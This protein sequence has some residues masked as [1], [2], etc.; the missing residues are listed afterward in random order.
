MPALPADG[1]ALL[2][3]VFVL[4]LRH[5]ID[6]D[7]IATIDGLTR[8]ASA[9]GRRLARWCGALFALGHGAA[10][11]ALVGALALAS[12]QWHPP[13]WVQ[14]LGAG[15][16]IGL[17]VAL[18]LANLRAA[19][20]A[21][22][23]DVVALRGLRGRLFDGLLGSGHP[24]AALG[25]GA[26]FAVSFDTL[27]VAVMLALSGAAGGG[28]VQALLLGALFAGGMLLTDGSNGW[29]LA[30]LLSRAGGGAPRASRLLAGVVGGV[31]LSV[32]AI[33]ALR[34][35]WPAADAWADASSGWL[36]AAVLAGLL[37]LSAVVLRPRTANGQPAAAASRAP[38]A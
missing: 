27:G 4:G 31:S 23:G 6:A 19:V 17:L 38:A 9:R 29:W 37:A 8:L 26:L 16:S 22:P 34:W 18:G 3:L 30:R 35:A 28:P 1:S 20:G 25:I 11:L 12:R 21:A 36:G 7:H 32:A 15:I 13:L 24:L 2:G 10:V 14:P 33:G 5:G